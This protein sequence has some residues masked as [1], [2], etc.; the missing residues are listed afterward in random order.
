MNNKSYVKTVDN[1][2]QLT[3][4]NGEEIS[5]PVKDNGN[6]KSAIKYFPNYHDVV[7]MNV[8]TVR[9][10]ELLAKPEDGN[11]TTLGLDC[12]VVGKRNDLNDI[13]LGSKIYIPSMSNSIF[14]PVED[15]K[16]SAHAIREFVRTTFPELSIGTAIALDKSRARV[17][18]NTTGNVV[19]ST[20]SSKE[21][22]DRVRNAGNVKNDILSLFDPTEDTIQVVAFTLVPAFDCKVSIVE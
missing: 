21:I 18:L 11:L 3:L 9:L 1:V 10:Y 13:A 2:L 19:I 7:L 17:G 15:N 20:V 6:A 4:A 22:E 8:Y 14:L 12:Y 16:Y 5:Y